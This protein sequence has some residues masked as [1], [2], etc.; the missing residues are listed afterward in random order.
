[1][2][3]KLRK[4]LPLDEDLIFHWRNLPQIYNLGKEKRPVGKDE[5]HKWYQ[6]VIESN[7]DLFFIITFSDIDCGVIRYNYLSGKTWEV[8]IYI[9]EKHSSGIGTEALN[10]SF[11][12]LPKDSEIIACILPENSRGVA[13]FN[14]NKFEKMQSHDFTLIKM[15]RKI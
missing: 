15:L 4:A 3:V 12:F 5:H 8:S 9:A 2:S 10:I 7:H 14:R 6:K 11:L 1:M 13:F